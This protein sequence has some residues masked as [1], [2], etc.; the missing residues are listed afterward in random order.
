MLGQLGALGLVVQHLLVVHAVDG[1]PLVAHL[2]QQH[3][4]RVGLLRVDVHYAHDAA[5]GAAAC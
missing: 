1:A 3:L 5:Y 2:H 4:V